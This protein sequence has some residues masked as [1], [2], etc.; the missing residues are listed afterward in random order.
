MF[1]K[2]QINVRRKIHFL[3]KRQME[4]EVKKII[5]EVDESKKSQQVPLYGGI[6]CKAGQRLGI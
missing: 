6:H 3:I 1:K 2:G 4:N 5:C